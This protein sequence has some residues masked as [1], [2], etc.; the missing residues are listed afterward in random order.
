[1]PQEGEQSTDQFWAPYKGYWTSKKGRSCNVLNETD[2]IKLRGNLYWLIEWLL[3]G[4][5][6]QYSSE[7]SD[8]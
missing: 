8:I 6:G 2:T 4:P 5:L 1:M 3:T 7:E